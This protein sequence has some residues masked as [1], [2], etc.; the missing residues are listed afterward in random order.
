MRYYLLW[1][2]LIALFCA[3]AYPG[4]AVRLGQ[5]SKDDDQSL[6]F[7]AG[8]QE[9][10]EIV[11]IL[12]LH[13]LFHR[14]NFTAIIDHTFTND[15]ELKRTDVVGG[16]R[17]WPI[18]HPAYVQLGVGFSRAASQEGVIIG[19]SGGYVWDI[20]RLWY[21][22]LNI[23]RDFISDSLNRWTLGLGVGKRF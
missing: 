1:L 23:G 10:G 13:P 3:P 18:D 6:I 15:P 12:Y 4:D 21:L 5:A 14:V 7:S 17:I 20:S 11:R 2:V 9:G 22:D 19:S 16:M 8:V